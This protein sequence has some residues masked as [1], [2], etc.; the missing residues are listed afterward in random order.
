[1]DLWTPG[2]TVIY[3]YT[4]PATDDSILLLAQTRGLL[5]LCVTD[6]RGAEAW[7]HMFKSKLCPSV[8]LAMGENNLTT[9]NL[10]FPICKGEIIK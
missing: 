9:L 5:I 2:L 6:S 4:T 3:K 1:M 7:L 8:E 10:I